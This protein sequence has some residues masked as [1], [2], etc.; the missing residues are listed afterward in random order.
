[1]NKLILTVSRKPANTLLLLTILV[2]L[3]FVLFSLLFGS[4]YTQVLQ[5]GSVTWNG[6]PTIPC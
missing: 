2:V 1:M 3:T 5:I 6:S 4:L